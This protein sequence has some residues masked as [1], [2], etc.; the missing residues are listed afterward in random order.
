MFI[1]LYLNCIRSPDD[2]HRDDYDNN[3]DDDDDEDDDD[4]DDDDDENDDSDTQVPMVHS[5]YLVNLKLEESDMLAYNPAKVIL[6][7]INHYHH[8]HNHHLQ[9][10]FRRHLII[11]IIEI[12]KKQVKDYSGPVDDMI[13]F[14]LS[15]LL[16]KNQ[17]FVDNTH[18]YGVSVKYLSNICSKANT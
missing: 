10:H 3:D 18:Y 6:I 15:A 5:C 17:I 16:N 14:A 1:L 2:D 12:I 4:D 7:V 9:H 11:T 8:H 13:V